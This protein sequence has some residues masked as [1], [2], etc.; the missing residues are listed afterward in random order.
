MKRNWLPLIIGFIITILVLG[1]V[2]IFLIFLPDKQS[3]NDEVALITI[4]PA[5]TSTP[6]IG[7]TIV[8]TS[9]ILSTK[10]TANNYK[11]K[12]GDFVQITGTS[13]DGLRL[14]AEPGRSYGV[15]FIGLDAEVFEVVD[16][17]VEEDGFTWWQLEAPYDNK[18]TGWS[19]DEYLQL[20][21][22]P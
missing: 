3:F 6:V 20:V 10:T 18:R 14:R 5:S 12:L 13:G 9:I 11:F 21:T 19:V 17:P 15:N 7:F 1:V 22:V 2:F 16:G 4:I 8:P